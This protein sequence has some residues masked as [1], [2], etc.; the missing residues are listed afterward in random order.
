MIDPLELH[1]YVDGELGKEE[2]ARIRQQLDKDPESL[3]EVE[4]IRNLK[5]AL[6]THVA[7]PD[8]RSEWNRCSARIKELQKTRRTERF[9]TR[10]AWALCGVF[11]LAIVAGGYLNRSTANGSTVQNA[12]LA[13]MVATLAPVGGPR[14]QAPHEVELWM[15]SMLGQARQS[16]ASSRLDIRGA[17]TGMVDGRRITRLACTDAKGDFSLV[18][19]DGILDASNLP[20][21]SDPRFKIAKIQGVNCVLWTDGRSTLC[22]V[23][24]RSYDDLVKLALE[25]LTN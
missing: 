3:R 25:R 23:A 12:D 15:D 18:V 20:S 10:N 11:F 17:A 7:A 4:R 24:D 21:H 5:Q 1:A 16:I 13:R 19:V 8:C 14:S 9:V 6:R 22:L 2:Q